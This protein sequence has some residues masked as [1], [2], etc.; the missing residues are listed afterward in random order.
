MPPATRR[1]PPPRKQKPSRPPDPFSPSFVPE[2][3]DGA[4]DAGVQV[5]E[6]GEKFTFSDRQR[7]QRWYDRARTLYAA[8]CGMKSADGGWDAGYNHARILYLIA[9]QFTLPASNTALLAQSIT[10]YRAILPRT[11]DGDTPLRALDA[12]FN[13]AL[14]LTQMAEWLEEGLPAGGGDVLVLREEALRLLYDVARVQEAYVLNDAA[15]TEEEQGEMET[16]ATSTTATGNDDRDGDNAATTTYEEHV[17]TYSAIVETLFEIIDTATSIWASLPSSRGS[18]TSS[19][20]E[21]YN[22]DSLPPTYTPLAISRILDRCATLA[23]QA[24]SPS[25]DAMVHIKRLE[26][27]LVVVSVTKTPRPA[28]SLDELSTLLDRVKD[29]WQAA[30]STT[31]NSA[32]TIDA[33][34]RVACA[35]VLVDGETY[36]ALR[37]GQDPSR[38]WHH[39]SS[40]TQVATTS[41]ALPPPPL[42]S[43]PLANTSTLLSLSFLSLRR[44]LLS[45]S[46]PTFSPSVTHRKQ[47]LMNAEVYANRGLKE[48][49]LSGMTSQVV[50]VGVGAGGGNGSSR[51]LS[52]G[53]PTTS[54]ASANNNSGTISLP[55]AVGWDRESLARNTIL[56]LLRCLYYQ[57]TLLLEPSSSDVAITAQQKAD[58]LLA[59]I[60]AL[61][62]T[63]SR[64]RWL[65][66]ADVG[67]FVDLLEDEEGGVSPSETAFWEQFAG[68]L[69]AE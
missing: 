33:E 30:A 9:T 36:L 69:E 52:I 10:A 5:E 22:L 37:T 31:T 13:L 58:K 6:K 49:G 48:L 1:P 66:R 59:Q 63:E 23:S 7:A 55:Q 25:L 41:L 20:A 42:T 45:L 43:S 65:G 50:T 17:P 51:T 14:C 46:H 19:S 60:Q 27:G 12:A 3:Y 32:T 24:N 61:R 11:L 35:H 40:A 57:S 26:A 29:V 8:A 34:T 44:A 56:S 21:E 16:E 53:L 67:R 15:T 28:P 38:A 47:L 54:S 4:L 39:L 68:K 62:R 2:T 18:N 64:E